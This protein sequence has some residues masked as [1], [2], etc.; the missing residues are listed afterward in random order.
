MR[1]RDRR[2]AGVSWCNLERYGIACPIIM[3]T[4]R[5]NTSRRLLA[6]AMLVIGGLLL[7]LASAEASDMVLLVVGIT[8]ATAGATLERRAE[9]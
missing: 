1:H 7:W 3:R 6:I 8:L 4:I 9:R 5:Y 2:K